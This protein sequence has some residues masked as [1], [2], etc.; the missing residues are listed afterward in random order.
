MANRGLYSK[1]IVVDESGDFPGVD[2]FF[3][4]GGA[5]VDLKEEVDQGFDV[6]RVEPLCVEGEFEGELLLW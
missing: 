3:C 2:L 1:V 6:L 5:V 4:E